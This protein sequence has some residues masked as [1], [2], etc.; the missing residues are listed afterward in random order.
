MRIILFIRSFVLSAN[1]DALNLAYDYHY[2]W[3][4]ENYRHVYLGFM[5]QI[6]SRGKMPDRDGVWL[7]N[8]VDGI[9]RNLADV[10]AYDVGTWRGRASAI[11]NGVFRFP[12]MIVDGSKAQGKD[13]CR[14]LLNRIKAGRVES[15]P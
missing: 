14:I 15:D 2:F 7:L 1:R 5:D 13:A 6:W 4:G 3:Q 11:R 10:R 12:A 9:K 8:E